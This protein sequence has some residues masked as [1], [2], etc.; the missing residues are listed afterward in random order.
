MRLWKRG[1]VWFC[2]VYDASGRRHRRSTRC[3]DRKAAEIVARRWEQAAADPAAAAA[4][5]STLDDALAGLLDRRGEQVKAGERAQGTLDMYEQ[6]GAQL[7]R[8]LGSDTLLVDL[9]PAS[10]DAYVTKRRSEQVVDHTIHKELTTLRAALRLAKR[11]RIWRGDLD[12]LMPILS[13]DYEPATRWLLPSDVKWLLACLDSRHAAAAAFSLATGAE[14][15]ALERATKADTNEPEVHIRGTKRKTRDRWVPLERPWQLSLMAHAKEHAQEDALVLEGEDFRAALKYAA[16]RAGID[17]VSPNDL[18]RTFATW[19][20]A[21]GVT[22]AT[23]AALLGHA[24]DRV[25]QRV[26]ARLPLSQLR[27]LMGV[28]LARAWDT[29]GTNRGG[30][31]ATGETPTRPNPLKLAPRVGFEPT[32]R[33]LTVRVEKWPLPRDYGHVGE[34]TQKRGTRAGQ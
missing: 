10:L 23:I 26:Y 34:S 33:G 28:E 7:A 11:A 29:G 13:A 3:H 8:V 19:L 32:T 17:H 6:K 14:L 31:A 9:T 5:A 22:L 21:E 16:R 25:L 30:S 18:R 27:L 20:R 15:G 12:E 24:D 2:S 1:D 4:Q